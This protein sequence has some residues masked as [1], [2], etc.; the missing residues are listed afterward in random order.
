MKRKLRAEV[1]NPTDANLKAAGEIF[2]A[3]ATAATPPAVTGVEIGLARACRFELDSGPW[4]YKFHVDA[5][6]GTFEVWV[7]DEATGAE[8]AHRSCDT[9]VSFT[10]KTL[11]FQVP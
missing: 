6:A 1:R 9:K 7:V 2:P 11:K 8:V 5:G 10:G 4:V 3:G